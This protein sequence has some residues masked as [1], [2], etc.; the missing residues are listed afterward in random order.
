MNLLTYFYTEEFLRGFQR[1]WFEDDRKTLKF[2]FSFVL[3]CTVTV[4]I[5]LVEGNPWWRFMDRHTAMFVVKPRDNFAFLSSVICLGWSKSRN[6]SIRTT[7]VPWSSRS[8]ELSRTES[9]RW[10]KK[11]GNFTWTT[12]KR[13]GEMSSAIFA[14]YRR[15][16]CS[17]CLR[18]R[19]I[20]PVALS[21]DRNISEVCLSLGKT[22]L[23]FFFKAG[24]RR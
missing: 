4:K 5:N 9:S 18:R 21:R 8:Q 20:I 7:R 10:L 1:F 16:R 15:F 12:S 19:G 2:L 23:E 17:F 13:Q 3:L 22:R 14:F 11:K 6:G 24:Y